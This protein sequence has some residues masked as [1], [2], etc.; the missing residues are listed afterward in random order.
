[1]GRILLLLFSLSCAS[2]SAQDI[3]LK[4]CASPECDRQAFQELMIGV[5][6]ALKEFQG[7]QFNDS[8][9]FELKRIDD[10]LIIENKYAW[11][12]PKATSYYAAVIKDQVDHSRLKNQTSYPIHWIQN[13]KIEK[14]AYVETDEVD[15]LPIPKAAKKFNSIGQRAAYLYYYDGYLDYELSQLNFEESLTADLFFEDGKLVAIDYLQ[16]PLKNKVAYQLMEKVKGLETEFEAKSIKAQYRM[17]YSSYTPTGNTKTDWEY[18]SHLEFY[19][20]NQLWE[21][22]RKI[23][24]DGRSLKDGK[25]ELDTAKRST[26]KLLA[27]YLGKALSESKVQSKW[28]VIKAVKSKPEKE[29]ADSD[30]V[31][32]AIIEEMPLYSG[33]DPEVPNDQRMNCLQVGFM[34][35]ASKNFKYPKKARKNEIQGTVYTSFVIEKD[36]SI[37]NVKISR[38]VHPLLDLECIRVISAIPQLDSPAKQR[39]KAVRMSFTFPINAKLN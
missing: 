4:G 19:T 15:L 3:P 13:A 12:N 21:P 18:I 32:F 36:G 29:E 24:A 25:I 20:N 27:N 14:E 38:S 33:C 17:R 28:W 1:M 2:I 35:H 34:K 9:Y 37:N 23:I 11:V 22:L 8:I 16:P 39:G 31:S 5:E 10:S 7:F 26:D 30:V 6:E